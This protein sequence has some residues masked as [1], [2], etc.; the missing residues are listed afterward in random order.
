L[1]TPEIEQVD[2]E[3]NGTKDYTSSTIGGLMNCL[4]CGKPLKR[5]HE[6]RCY[7]CDRTWRSAKDS[8]EGYPKYI[9]AM[10]KRDKVDQAISRNYFDD[11]H[12]NDRKR[13][14]IHTNHHEG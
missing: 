14:S 1:E 9:L 3:P 4:D 11:I 13:S 6:L 8:G 2:Q 7:D 12:G 5:K 10:W